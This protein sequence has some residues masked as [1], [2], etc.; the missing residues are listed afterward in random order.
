MPS[1]KIAALIDFY[2]SEVGKVNALFSPKFLHHRDH[3][4]SQVGAQRSGTPRETIVHGA[5]AKAVHPDIVRRVI[6]RH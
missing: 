6:G 2:I 1:P 4:V 3:I 5:C